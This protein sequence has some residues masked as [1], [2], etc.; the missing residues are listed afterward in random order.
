[1]RRIARESFVPSVAIS[2]PGGAR[3]RRPR[4]RRPHG[5]ARARGAEPRRRDRRAC[6]R[7]RLA[8]RSFRARPRRG[9]PAGSGLPDLGPGR[10]IRCLRSG[11][12]RPRRGGPRPAADERTGMDAGR[13]CRERAVAGDDSRRPVAPTAG[14][15]RNHGDG[16]R[17]GIPALPP[18]RRAGRAIRALRRRLARGIRRFR[19]C[20][21]DPDATLAERGTRAGDRP[22]AVVR[23]SRGRADVVDSRARRAASHRRADRERR[24]RSVPRDR[25]ARS[26][27]VPGRTAR[28]P[29]GG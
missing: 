12:P 17:P 7:R 11:T 29:V 26:G 15:E 27:R 14:R 19:R 10:A 24:R 9:H 16:P 1:M 21:P 28:T 20:A 13:R 8:R 5:L 22:R 6:T 25:R 3:P 18:R 23:A 2:R 4:P